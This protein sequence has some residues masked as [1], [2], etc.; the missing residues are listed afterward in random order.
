MGN[1]YPQFHYLLAGMGA[2]SKARRPRDRRPD[3]CYSRSRDELANDY[4]KMLRG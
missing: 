4:M 1:N 3:T 2:R